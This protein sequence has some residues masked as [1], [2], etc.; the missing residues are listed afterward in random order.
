MAKVAIQFEVELSQI[1]CGSCGGVYAI[2]ERYRE[3]Q[4][5]DGG[6]WTCPYC[7]CG[8]GYS[9]NNENSK[10][11]RQLKEEQERKDRALA[12][13]NTLRASLAAQ[14]AQTTKLRK[15][16]SNGVC[17]CCTRSFTNLRRHMATKHPEHAQG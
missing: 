12:E 5:Q 9:N 16:V 10:L 13:A 6:S 15:R 1:D 2:N 4:Y 8:W 11:K 17:P 3:K 7:K 14:K